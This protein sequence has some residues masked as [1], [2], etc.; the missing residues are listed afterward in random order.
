MLVLVNIDVTIYVIAK[1][2]Q[3]NQISSFLKIYP[4]MK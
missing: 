1:N 3:G 4:S 2:N